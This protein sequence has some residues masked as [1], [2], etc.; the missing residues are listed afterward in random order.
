MDCEVWVKMPAFWGSDSEDI[1]GEA[2]DRPPRK[3]LKGVPGIP[4]GSKLFYETITAHL[5]TMGWKPIAADKCSSLKERAVLIL[6]VD[7]FAF[8]HEHDKTWQTF[9]GQLRTRFTA[10]RRRSQRTYTNNEDLPVSYPV[11]VFGT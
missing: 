6:W 1:T 9:I 2:K 7:D 5:A 11:T 8:V 10:D 3:L 4:Q